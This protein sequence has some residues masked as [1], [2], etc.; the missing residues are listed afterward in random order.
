ML[1]EALGYNQVAF[2]NLVEISQPAMNNYERGIR[3]PD[4]DQAIK[5][6]LRTGAT[7]DWLYLGK[8]D[9]LPAHLLEKLPVLSDQPRKAG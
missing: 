5:I 6:Q 1:R 2:A 3:R 4:L 7:L 8:R 9:G